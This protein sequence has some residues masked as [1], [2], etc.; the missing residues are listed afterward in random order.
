MNKKGNVVAIVILA[1]IILVTVIVLMGDYFKAPVQPIVET[2]KMKEETD[3]AVQRAILLSISDLGK[4]G[5][6][7]SSNIWFCNIPVPPSLGE[8]QTAF[9]KLIDNNLKETLA[10]LKENRKYEFKGP[11]SINFTLSSNLESAKSVDVSLNQLNVSLKEGETMKEVELSNDYQ[12]KVRA[13]LMYKKLYDWASNDA[14]GLISNGCNLFAKPCQARQCSCEN[15]MNLLDANVVDSLR[16]GEKE[17][18]ETVENSIAALNKSFSGTGINC[19]YSITGKKVENILHRNYFA[20]SGCSCS[21]AETGWYSTQDEN[22]AICTAWNESPLQK[23][24]IIEV[25]ENPL[26]MELPL[27]EPSEGI[28]DSHVD[29]FHEL[30]GVERNIAV[31]FTVKC[32]DPQ[33][34][35]AAESG[36]E[37]F[38]AELAISMAINNPCPSPPPCNPNNRCD[39]VTPA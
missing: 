3:S 18:I 39:L 23:C 16:I 38:A 19:N 20:S 15:D 12:F 13:W 22:A 36:I 11:S 31:D 26:T 1:I 35:I 37:P 4:Q 14:G 28:D 9:K 34:R 32:I 17:V 30:V 2:K 8:A 6:S 25:N 10:A 5:Y 27:F 33:S 21:E 24:P 7:S 29:G